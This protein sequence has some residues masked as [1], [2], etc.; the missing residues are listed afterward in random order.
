MTQLP[1]KNEARSL[2]ALPTLELNYFFIVIFFIQVRAPL[3]SV[4]TAL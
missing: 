4:E 2:Q 3:E 1:P